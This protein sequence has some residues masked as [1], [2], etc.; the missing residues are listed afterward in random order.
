M[1]NVINKIQF[2]KSF[3]PINSH[4]N[5]ILFILTNLTKSLMSLSLNRKEFV[6]IF[7]TCVFNLGEIKKFVMQV[8]R[9]KTTEIRR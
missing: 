4:K 3:Y 6:Y 8:E 9:Q 2:S 1:S 7:C 5:T